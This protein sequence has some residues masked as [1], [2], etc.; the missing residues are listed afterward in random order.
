MDFLK[1]LKK[2][3]DKLVLSLVLFALAVVAVLL[4]VEVGSFKSHLDDQLKDRTGGKKKA[5]TPTDLTSYQAM[6]ARLSAPIQVPLGGDKAAFTASRWKKTPA[7]DVAPDTSRANQGPAGINGL[8]ITP[9]YLTID[10]AKVAGTPDSPRYEFAIGREFEKQA[11]KRGTLTLSARPGEGLRLPGQK[12]DLFRLLEVKGSPTEPAEL[13]IQ[14]TS[15]SD[16]PTVAPRKPFRQVMGYSAQFQ[17]GT[18]KRIFKNVRNEDSLPLS[19]TTY[20]VVAITESELVI[21]APNLVR[22]TIKA[23]QT[24]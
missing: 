19:G 21:S 14:L 2:H 7:G 4:L 10:F 15:S 23:T 1:K 17:Y 12:S 9:L 24:P 8:T 6:M 13:T 3:Y 22:T 11:A 16:R 5:F 20:K 18:E